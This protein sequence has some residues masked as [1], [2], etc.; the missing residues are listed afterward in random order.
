[1]KVCNCY[2]L[3]IQSDKVRISYLARTCR[4]VVWKNMCCFIDSPGEHDSL[5]WI[6]FGI[7]PSHAFNNLQYWFETKS[8]TVKWTEVN[9]AFILWFS[10][11]WLL[12]LY[13]TMSDIH[14]H[15]LAY[16][17]WWHRHLSMWNRDR[18]KTDETQYW[19][20]ICDILI[21]PSSMMKRI[22]GQINTT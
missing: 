6:S 18:K 11:L 9:S 5:Q 16:R 13:T 2:A 21:V 22:M 14:L 8:Y 19:Y 7:F 4:E 10:D 1:M 12:V 20:F 17:E 15:C 3:N